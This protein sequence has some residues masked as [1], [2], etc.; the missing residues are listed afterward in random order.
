MLSR[1]EDMVLADLFMSTKSIF[2]YVRL[3]VDMFHFVGFAGL[4]SFQ[5]W[6]TILAD[7]KAATG[8]FGH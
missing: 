4:L 6:I 7:R 8:T 2:S 1:N 3:F 5:V